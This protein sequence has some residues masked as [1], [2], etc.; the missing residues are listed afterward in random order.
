MKEKLAEEDRVQLKD[1]QRVGMY[2]QDIT[3]Y[4]ITT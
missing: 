2:S 1:I 3:E 4:L